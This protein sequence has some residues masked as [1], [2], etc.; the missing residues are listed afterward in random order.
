[1]LQNTL[2]SEKTMIISLKSSLLY[3]SRIFLNIFTNFTDKSSVIIA[4]FIF[5]ISN[6]FHDSTLKVLFLCRKRHCF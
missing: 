3:L 1:M 4:H 5:K 6:K 2:N